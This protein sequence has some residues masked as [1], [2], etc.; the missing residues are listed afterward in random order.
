[1]FDLSNTVQTKETKRREYTGELRPLP[2]RKSWGGKKGQILDKGRVGAIGR[3]IDEI[4][5]VGISR[6][7]K[8]SS[9]ERI[10]KLVTESAGE[11]KKEEIEK[12]AQTKGE[13]QRVIKEFI[14]EGIL[15]E[16]GEGK[17]K[18]E[19]REPKR[20]ITKE[21]K[22]EMEQKVAEIQKRIHRSEEEKD[23]EV[24]MEI[25]RYLK[26]IRPMVADKEEII[27]RVQK[28]STRYKLRAVRVLEEL[29][30]EG[31]VKE[32]YKIIKS[33][34]DK[35]RLT[36]FGIKD[37]EEREE[38]R[39]NRMK[40]IRFLQQEEKMCAYDEREIMEGTKITEY[41]KETMEELGAE[42]KIKVYRVGGQKY[43]KI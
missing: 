21:Q 7:I 2:K 34:E 42:G 13:A 15:V 26:E 29:R 25:L 22:K 38:I 8:G 10:I 14:K 19:A 33:G 39:R 5:E 28:E 11:I 37:E 12:V 35:I 27:K 9:K 23:E 6:E 3:N 17:Y 24:K 36:Y 32:Y 16:I 31:K 43:Y 30:R 40:V 20:E 1:M 4:L 41:L 18:H